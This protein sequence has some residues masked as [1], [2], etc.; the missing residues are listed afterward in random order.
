MVPVRLCRAFEMLASLLH[1]PIAL[2][3]A[4]AFVKKNVLVEIAGPKQFWEA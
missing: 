2:C 1:L 3:P 4:Q